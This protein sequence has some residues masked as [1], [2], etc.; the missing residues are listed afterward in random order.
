MYFQT[1]VSDFDLEPTI[2]GQKAVEEISVS[3]P[4]ESYLQ[5]SSITFR[6]RNLSIGV[7][8][9]LASSGAT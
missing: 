1:D 7:G 6:R 2:Q 9:L 3:M 4:S 8:T 5:L